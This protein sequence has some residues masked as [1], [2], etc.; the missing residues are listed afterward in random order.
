MTPD[1]RA[2]LAAERAARH[3]A[4]DAQRKAARRARRSRLLRRAAPIA[5]VG[6]VLVAGAHL[7]VTRPEG[8]DA[9]AASQAAAVP[10][11]QTIANGPLATE[12]GSGLLA[13]RLEGTTDP[14]PVDFKD[15][16]KA[17]LLFDLDDG[18][19]MWR[20]NESA[21]L[22]IASVTKLMTALV[23]V[24]EL[25]PAAKVKIAPQA[26]RYSGSGVG[27][28]PKN[29]PVGVSALLHGLLLAS[30]NDAAKALAIGAAGSE[31]EF[32]RQM[33]AR[34]REM[35]LSC[36]RFS[37]PSGIID[38]RN[39][40]CAADLAVLARAVLDEPRL[41]KIVKRRSAVLPFP[42]KGGKLWLSNHNP[43][44]KEGY[45]G[46]IGL[47]TGYT[48]AAGKTFVAAVRRGK[49]RY[50]VVLLDTPDMAKQAKQLFGRAYRLDG[51]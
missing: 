22:P 28:L 1:R 9:S 51:T 20:R 29:K 17:G 21:K 10:A 37:S 46:T 35:G 48:D 4:R 2:E 8:A 50:G 47:K 31:K 15:P 36:T 18:R 13:L 41:A 40:S 42:M 3:A 16:P 43:L 44:L 38:Y 32:V 6:A 26:L 33:N 24:D 34:A 14:F 7:A 49:H 12:H 39:H 25:G 11:G 5:A 23:V 27:V 30:G 45:P 19:V